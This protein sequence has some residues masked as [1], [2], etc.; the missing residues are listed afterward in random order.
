M[1]IHGCFAPALKPRPVQSGFGLIELMV[2]LSIVAVLS[3]ASASYFRQTLESARV[4]RIQEALVAD[5]RFTQSEA[6]RRGTTVTLEHLSCAT[7]TAPASTE[8]WSCGWVIFL[9]QDD[10]DSYQSDKDTL[11]KRSHFE[12]PTLVYAAKTAVRYSPVG[13]TTDIQTIYIGSTATF[14]TVAWVRINT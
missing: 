5:L 2:T 8:N 13:S 12:Y 1:H 9:N 3:A 10:T 7:P 11:L 6:L 14:V 4:R